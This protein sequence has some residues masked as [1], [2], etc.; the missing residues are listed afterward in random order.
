MGA[1]GVNLEMIKINKYHIIY[2]RYN[3]IKR[4]CS[5]I[6]V[7]IDLVWDWLKR[8]NFDIEG[9]LTISKDGE[10]LYIIG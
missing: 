6:D 5:I 10:N 9:D 3:V 2:K 8:H 1:P 7:D 4:A